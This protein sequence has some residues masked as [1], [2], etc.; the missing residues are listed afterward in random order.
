MFDHIAPTYD[1]LNRLLSFGRDVS[2]RRRAAR[3][4]EDRGPVRVVDLATGTADLLI[5][6]L[7][8]RPRIVDAI[9]LDCSDEMLRLGRRK[10]DRWGLSHRARLV[11]GDATST[12][13][14]DASFDAVAMAFGIRN[15]PDVRTTLDEIHRLLRPGGTVVIL[16]FSLPESPIMR[17]GYLAYL[18]FVVPLIGA[19]VSGDRRAYR[20][21]NRSIEDFHRPAAF[22][23]LMERAGFRDVSVTPLTGGVASIYKGS[24]VLSE[25]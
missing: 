18:R 7:R 2:W 21:L 4:V 9:G 16:E 17:W 25:V 3:C 10:M 20:Y 15:T 5:A 14:P 8:E 13:F 22:R 23:T 1:L 19:I 6:L 24:K 11:Q 12:L